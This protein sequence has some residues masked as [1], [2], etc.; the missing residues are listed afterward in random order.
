VPDRDEDPI[1]ESPCRHTDGP[2]AITRH[3]AGPTRT[4]ESSTVLFLLADAY[5]EAFGP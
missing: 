3:F 2:A 4:G 5:R 1:R